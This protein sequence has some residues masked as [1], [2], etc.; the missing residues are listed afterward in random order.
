MHQKQCRMMGGVWLPIYCL[1]K[2]ATSKLWTDYT[3]ACKQ[4]GTFVDG[5]QD[6]VEL[7]LNE[8]EVCLHIWEEE[9]QHLLRPIQYESSSHWKCNKLCTKRSSK[10]MDDWIDE[11]SITKKKQLWS[12]TMHSGGCTNN[13][14]SLPETHL[15][16]R[17]Y[18]WIGFV[19]HRLSNQ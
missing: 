2:S 5:Y 4:A 11:R 12:V 6:L 9:H 1:T 8:Y 3:P 16:N 7:Y 19:C 14:R 15:K 13:G 18:A 17:I 10:P